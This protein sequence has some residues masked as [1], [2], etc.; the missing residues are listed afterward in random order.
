MPSLTGAESTLKGAR[1]MLRELKADIS[2]LSQPKTETVTVQRHP[3]K[4]GTLR[5]K[6]PK[7]TDDISA[8]VGTFAVALQ[9]SL[10]HVIH[11]LWELD[12]GKPIPPRRGKFPIC[13]S[14][15]DFRSRIEPDL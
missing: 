9:S 1:K 10:N 6:L 7:R 12:T 8:Q 13:K 14:P 15:D 11:A 5:A 2:D 4:P 3:R